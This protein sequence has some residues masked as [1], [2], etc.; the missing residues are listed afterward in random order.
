MTNEELFEKL[1]K[2]LSEDFEVDASSITPE[3]NLVTDLDL[4]SIDFI[5]LVVK[6]KEFI[7]VKIDPEIFKSVKTVQD[8]VDAL[9]PYTKS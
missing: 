6:T 9:L 8:A 2:I 1:K 7:P 3:A 4:D 5:D